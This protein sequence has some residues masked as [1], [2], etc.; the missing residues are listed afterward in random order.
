[1]IGIRIYTPYGFSSL[2]LT[3]FLIGFN[4]ELRDVNIG[5]DF[6]GRGKR[7]YSPMLMRFLSSDESSPLYEGGLNAYAYCEADPVNYSDPSAMSRWAGIVRQKVFAS[8]RRAELKRKLPLQEEAID[9]STPRKKPAGG[10][11]RRYESSEPPPVTEAYWAR[12]KRPHNVAKELASFMVDNYKA[13]AANS[14]R[15][16]SAEVLASAIAYNFEIGSDHLLAWPGMKDFLN[17]KSYKNPG[18]AKMALRRNI[19]R[20]IRFHLKRDASQVRTE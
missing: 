7:L 11:V 8:G 1:M 19:N 12:N 4:G 3:D 20:V 17:S 6:L 18:T 10:R 15:G 16:V 2:A 9:L 5:C 14:A 13:Y